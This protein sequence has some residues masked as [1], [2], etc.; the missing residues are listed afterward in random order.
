MTTSSKNLK[1]Y[2]NFFVTTNTLKKSSSF[3]I[4]APVPQKLKYS[5]YLLF[6]GYPVTDKTIYHQ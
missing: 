4:K 1:L 3:K 6:L 2:K 5:M